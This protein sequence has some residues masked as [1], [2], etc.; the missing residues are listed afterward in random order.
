MVKC[1]KN[2]KLNRIKI[3]QILSVD[4]KELISDAKESSTK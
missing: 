1:N 2:M 4:M 3:E